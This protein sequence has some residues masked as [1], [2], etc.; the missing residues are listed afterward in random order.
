MSNRTASLVLLV[1]AAALGLG[2]CATTG[3][4]RD[5]LQVTV[6]GIDPLPGEGLELRM[7]VKLRVQNPN[8]TAI[9]FS[10][11]AVRLD[12]FDKTF[13]S[14]VSDATGTVPRYGETVVSV[15]VTVSAF[16]M[17]RQVMGMLDGKPVD[18]V[19]YALSG[20][21][22]GGTFRTIRFSSRGELDVPGS[23]AA[24]EARAPGTTL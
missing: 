11:A 18:K 6:A 17:A 3:P 22:S 14:G 24:G 19:P 2:A 12:V 20:K 7:L 8:E 4:A 10:G 23:R 15:P 5:P 21:L 1:C 13:A 9:A 16:R